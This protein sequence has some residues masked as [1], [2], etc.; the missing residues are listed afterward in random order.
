MKRLTGA[1]VRAPELQP[2]L[3]QTPSVAEPQ[4][5]DPYLGVILTTLHPDLQYPV[6]SLLSTWDRW[7]HLVQS[8][9]PVEGGCDALTHS[10][11]TLS[12]QPQIRISSSSHC[13]FCSIS[14]FHYLHLHSLNN[15]DN[16][17]LSGLMRGLGETSTGLG[18]NQ[19]PPLSHPLPRPPSLGPVLHPLSLSQDPSER[20]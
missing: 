14:L 18:S 9:P 13:L 7:T 8:S 5:F 6:T 16:T 3:H 20:E 11:S 12:H 2:L 17:C 15:E 10:L 4:A 1:E 19:T